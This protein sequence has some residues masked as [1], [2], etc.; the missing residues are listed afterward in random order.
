M[1]LIFSSLF[2]F[3][4]WFLLFKLFF[5]DFEDLKKTAKNNLFWG[6][7]D[8][9]LHSLLNA[10]TGIGGIRFLIYAALGLLGG[11]SLYLIL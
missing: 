3:L 2:T 7:I 5:D 1:K 9:I 6:T 4:I 8:F 11:F 10:D